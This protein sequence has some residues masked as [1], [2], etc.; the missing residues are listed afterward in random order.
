MISK[1]VEGMLEA[2]VPRGAL[3]TTQRAS[4][5][6]HRVR[7]LKDIYLSCAIEQGGAEVEGSVQAVR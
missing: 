5:H 7:L 3:R 2:P 6:P 1:T 4:N